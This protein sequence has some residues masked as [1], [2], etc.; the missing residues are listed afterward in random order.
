MGVAICVVLKC[1]KELLDAERHGA[2][3]CCAMPCSSCVV[4]C[5]N[6]IVL[7]ERNRALTRSNGQYLFIDL[8]H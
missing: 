3:V 2:V 8:P 4:V 7:L 5:N 1:R 6:V